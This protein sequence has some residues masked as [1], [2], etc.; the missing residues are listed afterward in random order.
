MVGAHI[1]AELP[2][3]HWE[4]P[5]A[6]LRCATFEEA[7]E[8]MRSSHFQP[9][10]PQERD[11][12]T[13]L[14]EVHVYREYSRHLDLAWEVVEKLSVTQG[15]LNVR[16]EGGRWIASFGQFTSVSAVT[17][18]LAICLAGLLVCGI[19]VELMGSAGF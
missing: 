13:L 2:R 5:N 3:T 14:R 6:H 18:P 19:E 1:T 9:F 7:L 8:V 12:A 4:D 15:S 10:A 11:P 17:A 16:F